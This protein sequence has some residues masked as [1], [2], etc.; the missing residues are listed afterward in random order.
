LK[1]TCVIFDMDGLMFDTQCIY[2]R[3]FH[4]ILLRDYGLELPDALRLAM[5]GRSGD[6]LYQTINRFFPGIDAPE[7]VR[8]SFAAVADRVRDELVSCP[9]CANR[10]SGWVWPAGVTAPSWR[11]TCASP[12]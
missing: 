11:A 1:K 8:R 3:A 10:A 5:M 12:A 2:D 7:Y 9:G 4:D 6:D